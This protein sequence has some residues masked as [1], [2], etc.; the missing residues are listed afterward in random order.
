MEQVTLVARIVVVMVTALPI[1][2]SAWNISGHMLS[3]IIAYQILQKES[4]KTIDNVKVVLEKHPWYANQWRTR[5]QAVAVADRDIVLFMQAA[6]GLMNF[7]SRTANITG[8]HGTTSTGL[9]SRR[10][11]RQASN[12]GHL[13]Q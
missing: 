7:V 3:G 11:N 2:A 12:R 6:S 4:P 13:S 1:P 9:L 5:L 10:V 8:G